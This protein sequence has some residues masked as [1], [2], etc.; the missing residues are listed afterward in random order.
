MR[1]YLR[2][3]LKIGVVVGAVMAFSFGAP[4]ILAGALGYFG[5]RFADGIGTSPSSPDSVDKAL[6][7]NA[8]SAGRDRSVSR[9]LLSGWRLSG[10]PIDMTVDSV[11]GRDTSFTAAGIKGLVT[12]HQRPL[13]GKVDFSVAM[14]NQG[15][16]EQADKVIKDRGLDAEVVRG[17][18]GKFNVVCSDVN[19]ANELAKALYPLR[20]VEVERRQEHHRQYIVSGM[21]SYQ[22][23]EEFLKRNPQTGGKLVNSFIKVTDVIDGKV[24]G[25]HLQNAPL[26]NSFND[27]SLPVGTFIVDVVEE[28]VCKGVS[29]VPSGTTDVSDHVFNHF[30][31]AGGNIDSKEPSFFNGTPDGVSRTVTVGSSKEKVVIHDTRAAS[32]LNAYVCVD[33]YSELRNLCNSGISAGS[34]VRVGTEVPKDMKG[35]YVLELPLYDSRVLGAVKSDVSVGRSKE[36]LLKMNGYDENVFDISY[37]IHAVRNDRNG[38][39]VKAYISEELY[40][41]VLASVANCNGVPFETCVNRLNEERMMELSPAGLRQWGEDFNEVR[42]VNF[43]IDPSRNVVKITSVIGDSKMKTEELPLDK[44]QMN[45]L[46]SRGTLSR[47]EMT[48]MLM[49]LHPDYFKT[50]SAGNGKS[51][52]DNPVES[53]VRGT[54]PEP[55]RKGSV[56]T[57][58]PVLPKVKK[59]SQHKL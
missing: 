7:A 4:L 6:K 56:I 22:E 37:L 17:R 49:Q 46:V 48:D 1:R 41:S 47:T 54:C 39:G 38:H 44:E 57:R 24:A 30:I 32:R 42:M 43:D 33:S 40:S 28:S 50:Y 5:Y 45:A 59:G 12:A 2:A 58:Q 23:A 25:E 11:K 3:A 21:G 20:D 36:E 51:S 34:E 15:M 10:L 55:A 27:G 8:E 31:A 53:F 35:K 13:Y 18:D 19:L 9:G 29:S 16:A 52:L 14:Q 26:D